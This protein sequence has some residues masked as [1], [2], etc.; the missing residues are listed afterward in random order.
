MND[1]PA[2]DLQPWLERYRHVVPPLAELADTTGDETLPRRLE[3]HER[4][5]PALE[6]ALWEGAEDFDG[7]LGCYQALFRDYEA[8]RQQ[9]EERAEV[10]PRHHFILSIPV[11]DR[12]QHL[13]A[14]LESIYRTCQA[15]GYGGMEN[16]RFRRVEVVVAEDSR[17]EDSIR[18]HQAIAAEYRAKGLTVHHF[19]LEE[20]YE[21]LHAIPP[22]ERALLGSLLTTQPKDRFYLKGQAANRNLSYLKCLQLTRDPG[23]TLYYFVDSDERFCV[24]RPGGEAVHALN[25]FHYIDR[26]FRET[27]TLVLTGKMVGDPPV[28]PSVMAANFLGDVTAF[29]QALAQREG[30]ESCS[31]HGAPP[32]A[33]ALASAAVYHDMA[34]L[35]GFDDTRKPLAYRCPLEG[36]HDHADCLRHFAARLP[37]F[38]FGVHLT[39]RTYFSHGDGFATL[40]PARTLYP[41]NYIANREGL[42]YVIPFGQL[43]LRMSGPTAGR[44]FAAEIGDRFATINL[45]HLHRRTTGDDLAGSFRPGVESPAGAGPARIDISDE[46]E[47]QF[48]GD[49]MLFTTEAL[50][51]EA[52]MEEPFTGDQVKRH[53]DE[54]EEALLE[55]YRRTRKDVLERNR[56]LRETVF[57]TGHWWHR[58]PA[59]AEALAQV[60]GFIDNIDY[61]F[62][63]DS[64]AWAKIRSETHRAARKAQ[65]LDALIGHHQV[66]EAWARL[67]DTL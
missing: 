15:F 6:R 21:L 5:F 14:C 16:G 28:S 61:N 31:F 46:Y 60:K 50:V 59:T 62:G 17:G 56:R 37:A 10:E 53:L 45:P 13:R 52:G 35:F 44:L 66:K 23:R 19:G 41:G 54:Q 38:F 48:F 33:R 26:A 49:L 18:Q 57:G 9:A 42:K 8:L 4:C 20:Q 25:Y 36:S 12:P 58:H 34:G 27:D 32:A 11:A 55:L 22:E 40:T 29:F 64:P 1:A 7:L 2:P 43:R 39:R 30:S 65:I 24:D 51:R 67:L 47:R 3:R 63:E